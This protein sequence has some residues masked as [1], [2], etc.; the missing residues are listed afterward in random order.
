VNPKP[1][2]SEGPGV[3]RQMVRFFCVGLAATAVHVVIAAH[4]IGTQMMPP[5][6]GN[7]IA[8]VCANLFSYFSQSHYVF[9][10]RPAPMQYWRFLNVSLVGLVLVAAISVGLEAL[11]VHYAVGI[12]AVVLVVPVATFGLHSLW[13]F[14][15]G[16]EGEACP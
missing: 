11:G 3:P 15:D 16:R 9:Q 7:A 13:T 10:K 8:F 2:P 5:E 14:R 6:L 4:L 12:A 1:L